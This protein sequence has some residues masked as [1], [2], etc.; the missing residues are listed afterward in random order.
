MTKLEEYRLLNQNVRA[1]RKALHAAQAQITETI[2]TPNW[3]NYSS[4][5]KCINRYS[6]MTMPWFA[7][8]SFED[9]EFVRYCKD[10]NCHKLCQNNACA[11]E[12]QNWN[13]VAAQIAYDDARRER[14][15]FVRNLFRGRA[16]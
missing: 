12:E 16:K 8:T 3:E 4:V 14:R 10:Y 1:A 7:K 9:I 11:C 5:V 2:E 13:A 15:V 6:K